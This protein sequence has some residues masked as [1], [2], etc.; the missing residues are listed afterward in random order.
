MGERAPTE[1]ILKL[2]RL[3]CPVILMD[4]EKEAEGD[5]FCAAAV[6]T[7]EAVQ[8]MI[9]RASG[10]LCMSQPR[11]RLEEIGIPRLSEGLELLA[12]YASYAPPRNGAS[13]LPAWTKF[14]ASMAGRFA[15]TPFHMPL[16]LATHDSGISVVERLE[17]IQALL[18]PDATIDSFV[19]PGH[20]F[21]LGAHAEGMSG[22]WGH[23]EASVDLCRAADLAPAGLLCE[24]VGDDGTMLR[25][26]DLEGFAAETHVEIVS[27]S[28]IPGLLNRQ[29]VAI[30]A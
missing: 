20:L 1:Q 26:E 14:L 7:P 2:V 8:F 9:R 4:E 12:S 28:A 18:E 17:T 3:G 29:A 5:L 27:L 15:G 13:V 21:T 10:L 16:D 30:P 11:D 23:T 24:I 6:A 22:R 19:A 25:G